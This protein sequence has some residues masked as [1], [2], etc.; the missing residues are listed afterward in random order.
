MTHE[1]RIGGVGDQFRDAA[2]PG[3]IFWIGWPRHA[4][5]RYEIVGAQILPEHRFPIDLPG[6]TSGLTST[7][8]HQDRLRLGVRRDHRMLGSRMNRA[9]P[10]TAG[11][12]ATV[13]EMGELTSPSADT[14]MLVRPGCNAVTRP[15][16]LTVATS[17]LDDS[18]VKRSGWTDPP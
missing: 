10:P 9:A 16:L 15:R 4:R 2:R 17:R 14:L 5:G 3:L 11:G 7:V 18:Y 12:A 6:P 8:N 13:T 1:H